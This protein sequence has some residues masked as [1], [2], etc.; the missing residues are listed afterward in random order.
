MIDL[1]QDDPPVTNKPRSYLKESL[2]TK[3]FPPEHFAARIPL[4]ES[5]MVHQPL[6]QSMSPPHSWRPRHSVTFA[7]DEESISPITIQTTRDYQSVRNP[8]QPGLKT[9]AFSC[10]V[11][12]SLL[13]V[14]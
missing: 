7:L 2:S 13:I 8:P 1:T 14:H 6:K 5:T 10:T 4:L 3:D 12:K 9:S 11:T